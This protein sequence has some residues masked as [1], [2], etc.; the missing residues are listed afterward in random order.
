MSK[1]Y[2]CAKG[3]GSIEETD[4]NEVPTCCDVAMVEINEDEIFGCS[5]CCHCCSGCGPEEDEE[6]EEVKE[7]SEKK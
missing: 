2:K 1:L 7:S 5:G 3:C 6:V 4:K